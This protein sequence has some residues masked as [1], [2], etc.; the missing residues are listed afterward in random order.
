MK[1]SIRKFVG[2][3]VAATIGT[4]LGLMAFVA[5]MSLIELF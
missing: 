2:V 3:V 5:T 1:T 4:F